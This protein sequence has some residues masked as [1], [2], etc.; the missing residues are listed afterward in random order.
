V[1]GHDPGGGRDWAL[2]GNTC[3]FIF[4]S[5]LAKS[6][7]ETHCF[8]A[9]P[10]MPDNHGKIKCAPSDCQQ[11]AAKTK[12]TRADVC[13]TSDQAEL[14]QRIVQMLPQVA[15]GIM[16]DVSGC[17]RVVTLSLF[18]PIEIRRQ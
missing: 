3:R 11:P 7:P 8:H 1:T 6:T 2:Q 18:T 5:F 16:Y 13:T 10:G 9:G 14:E 15:S 4:T 17:C 12:Y